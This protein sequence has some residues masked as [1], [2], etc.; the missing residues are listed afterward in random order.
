MTGTRSLAIRATT[1]TPARDRANATVCTCSRTHPASSS[2]VSVMVLTLDGCPVSSTSSGGSQRANVIDARGE[3]S[4]VTGV[5]GIPRSR[6][7][8]SSGSATVADAKTKVGS[9]R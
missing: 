4:R 5:T 3:P 8:C 9:E 6:E 2:P 1:S 7:A